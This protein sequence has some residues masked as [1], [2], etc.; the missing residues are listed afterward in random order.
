MKLTLTLLSLLIFLSILFEGVYRTEL[1]VLKKEAQQIRKAKKAKNLKVVLFKD[2][3]KLWL[4]KGEEVNLSQSG[5]LV[6]ENFSGTNFVEFFKVSSQLAIY[7]PWVATIVLSGNVKFEKF[8]RSGKVIETLTANRAVINLRK[9]KIF[10]YGKVI[11]NRG[12]ITLVG[13]DFI[14]DTKSGRFIILKD[15]QTYLGTR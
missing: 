10:G 11:L 6:F 8:N 3:K 13:K 9:N 5:E 15:V 4:L 2:L 7:K 12:K 14:Y 1:N